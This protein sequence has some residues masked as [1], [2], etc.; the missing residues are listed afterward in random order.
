MNRALRILVVDDDLRLTATLS[1]ILTWQGYET[2]RAANGTQALEMAQKI[3]FDCVISDIHMP[4]M[5]GV[6]LHEALRAIDPNL[7]FVLMTAY[8]APERIQAG[9]EQGVLAV[10]KKPLQIDRFLGFLALLQASRKV[11]IVDDD[12]HFAQTL[13]DIL[14]GH[15]FTAK[16]ITDPHRVL[17]EI[18]GQEEI[19]LLDMKLNG[20]DGCQVLQDI[21]DRHD[22][23]PAI[24]ITGYGREME[25]SI[26]QAL[27]LDAYACLYKPLVI[28]DLLALLEDIRVR[29]LQKALVK[30]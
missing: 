29:Q 12:P 27:D 23:M 20:I 25:K 4:G 5:D 18:S 6:A 15:G 8:A 10:L 11:V 2:E 24:L 17:E 9:H 3:S 14:K 1:D 7:P 26:Q 28:E 30:A 21:R 16:K 13:G 19:V 22:Q